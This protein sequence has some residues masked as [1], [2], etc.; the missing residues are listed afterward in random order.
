MPQ[1]ESAKFTGNWKA[2]FICPN[3]KII[4]DLAPLLSRHLPA[5]SGH[6]LHT[7]PTRHQMAELLATQRISI[8][9]L[10][11]GEPHDQPLAVIMELL[12]VDPKLPIVVILSGNDPELVLRCLR[13]GASDFLMQPFTSEQVEAALQKISR[14]HP[15]RSKTPGKVYCIMP[16]KGGCGASTIASNLA[17]QLKRLEDKRILLADLDPLAGT[18]SFLLKIKSNYSFM[19]VLARSGEID[20]DLWKAVITHR[21]GVDVLLSPE[22]MTDGI[23]DLKDAS[24]IIEY[25]RGAYDLVVLDAG[26]VYGDWNLSQAHLADEILLITTNELTSLQA[27]QRALSYLDASSVGR[28]KVRLIVNRYDRHVGLSRDVIGTALHTEI[29]HLMPT[30]YEAIQKSLMEGKPLAASTNFGKSVIGLVDRLGGSSEPQKKSTS[31]SGL[32]SLFSRTSS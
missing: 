11:V 28:Y 7:Y 3:P 19:D 21:G 30:D 25:A 32:L 22:V 4:R 14:L 23:S 18:L 6:E 5:F 31:L 26:S 2:L 15:G 9:F 12:R 13:Q 16:A 24:A 27:V 29:Y 17:Y 20:Q 10:E 8:C 1:P